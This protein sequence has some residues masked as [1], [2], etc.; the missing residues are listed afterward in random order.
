VGLIAHSAPEVD[1]NQLL[2]FSLRNSPD[3]YA[4]SIYSA[5]RQLDA[6]GADV[7]I[8]E[9]IDERGEGAAVM[10]RLR[11]AASETITT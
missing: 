1:S 4:H 7:I 5:M 9:A 8:I 6:W 10:D 2:V 11:R 3:D